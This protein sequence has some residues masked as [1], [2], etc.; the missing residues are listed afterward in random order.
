MIND[1]KFVFLL[2]LGLSCSPSKPVDRFVP[3]PPN[4]MAKLIAEIAIVDGT[5]S[6]ANTYQMSDSIVPAD[7]YSEVLK[8]HNISR[9]AFDSNLSYYAVHYQEFEK[10][11]DS[12][13]VEI[14]KR[15]K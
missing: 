2:A 7:L 5:I 4:E 6:L 10:V 14:A 15:R 11:L 13:L 12:S 9:S 3:L 8:Q 1:L